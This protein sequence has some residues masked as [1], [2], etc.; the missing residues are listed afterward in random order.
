MPSK[1]DKC[2]KEAF[3]KLKQAGKL[4]DLEIEFEQNW[5]R[6]KSTGE[7][8]NAGGNW[9]RLYNDLKQKVGLPFSDSVEIRRPDMTITKRSNTFVVDNKSTNSKGK[10]DP[11]R[12]GQ[13]E[14][15]NEINKDT[16]VKDAS[17]NENNCD[18][19][20]RGEPKPELVP[21]P[22]LQP[23][24]NLYFMPLPSPGGI[25]VPGIPTVPS[26]PPILEPV[27]IFP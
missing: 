5:V 23:G 13:R 10:I 26:L 21:D 15:H 17:L 14:A 20:G 19:K 18:C 25:T 6:N 4:G 2:F 3:E 27:P 9:W 1:K 16:Y 7:W 22:A 11:W 24:F 8:T 12:D